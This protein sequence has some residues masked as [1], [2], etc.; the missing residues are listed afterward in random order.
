[1]E[2]AVKGEV[3]RHVKW[4][5]VQFREPPPSLNPLPAPNLICLDVPVPKTLEGIGL[6]G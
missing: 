6:G 2:H 1:M 5:R 3:Q 4:V